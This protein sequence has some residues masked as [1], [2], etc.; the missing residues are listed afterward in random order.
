M[1][2]KNSIFGVEIPDCCAINI[3]NTH[4]GLRVRISVD[5]PDKTIHMV[6]IILFNLMTENHKDFLE[7]DMRDMVN[8]IR[9][10]VNE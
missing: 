1:E 3:S 9:K 10:Y 5:L 8:G 7:S 4:V 2:L 6:R